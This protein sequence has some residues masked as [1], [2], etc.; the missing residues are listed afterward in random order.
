M[1]ERT[2][3]LASVA[4]TIKTYRKGEIPEPTPE[5][6]GCWLEQFTPAA[7]LPFLREFDYVMKESFL[8]R[9]RI[10]NFLDELIKNPKIVGSH[11][12]LYW[13]L[14]NFLDIQKNGN[15]QAEMLSIFAKKIKYQYGINIKEDGCINGEFI[16]ID[17]VIFSGTR[18]IQDL[19]PW[20]FNQAPE[21]AVIN[22]IVIASHSGGEYHAHTRINNAIEKS[23]KKITVNYWCEFEVETRKSYRNRSQILWP[24]AI[25]RTTEVQAYMSLHSNSPFIPRQAFNTSVSSPFSS[26]AGRQILESEFFIAGA[27]I[28]AMSKNP[29]QVMRPLGYSFFGVGFGS[30]IVT[31]R[32][33]PNNCP[34]AIWW[35]DPEVTSGAL[36]WYPLMPRKGYFS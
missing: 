8:A 5:H 28:I 32:N 27:K 24:T 13:S 11:P 25:P 17:D 3:L 20:I 9:N 4:N 29:K 2:D 1:S 31:Y 30:M 36:N 22:I 33:C 14:V 34:L 6:V 10:E 16:Y 18:V 7:Q 35:G 19:E 15:S 23:G 12:D 26:E 21:L